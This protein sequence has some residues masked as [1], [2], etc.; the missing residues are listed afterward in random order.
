MTDHHGVGMSDR[1]TTPRD[2][3]RDA[4]KRVVEAHAM[5]CSTCTLDAAVLA[6][7]VLHHAIDALRKALEETA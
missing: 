4:A 2:P 5:Y 7:V 6:G 3:V 1:C